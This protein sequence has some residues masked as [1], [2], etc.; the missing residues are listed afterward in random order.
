MLRYLHGGGGAS[1]E[2]HVD[3]GFPQLP[4][5]L[6]LAPFV[7]LAG[8]AVP[9][10]QLVAQRVLVD[11]RDGGDVGDGREATRQLLYLVELAL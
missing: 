4:G 3:V 1:R 6:R 11:A 5:G 10:A 2:G 7:G 9:V 8:W